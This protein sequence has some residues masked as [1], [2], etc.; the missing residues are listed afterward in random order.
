MILG[1]L[2][3]PTSNST[4]TLELRHQMDISTEVPVHHSPSVIYSGLLPYLLLT[5]CYLGL[6]EKKNNLIF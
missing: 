2:L 1:C 3:K 4:F 5:V 6:N